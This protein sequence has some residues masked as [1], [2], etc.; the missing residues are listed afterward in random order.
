[1]THTP[2][3]RMPGATV[4]D[5]LANDTD[6]DADTLT[7][8]RVTQPDHGTVTLVGGLVNMDRHFQPYFQ[9]DIDDQSTHKGAPLF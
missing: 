8:D 5:V 2:S 9:P 1:M 6:L 4:I 7:V 3:L